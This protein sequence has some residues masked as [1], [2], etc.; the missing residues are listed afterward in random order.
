MND[1]S[2]VT[3]SSSPLKNSEVCLI[4]PEICDDDKQNS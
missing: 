3:S 1:S 2:L 4:C